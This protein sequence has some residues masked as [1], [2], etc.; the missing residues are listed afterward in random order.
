MKVKQQSLIFKSQR[1]LIWK[2]MASQSWFGSPASTVRHLE[3]W[4]DR[5]TDLH[6]RTTSLPSYRYHTRYRRRR[7]ASQSRNEQRGRKRD[8]NWDRIWGAERPLQGW[9]ER[10]GGELYRGGSCDVCDVDW[11]VLCNYCDMLV[12]CVAAWLDNRCGRLARAKPTATRAN[13]TVEESAP[14]WDQK[15]TGERQYLVQYYFFNCFLLI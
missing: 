5:T 2:K 4:Q 7:R 1:S 9:D 13:E 3:P 11:Y 6:P 14:L 15:L 12:Q 10:G 8:C